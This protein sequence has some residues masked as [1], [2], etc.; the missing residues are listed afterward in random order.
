MATPLKETAETRK[1]TFDGSIDEI[2]VK[3]HKAFALYHGSDGKIRIGEQ[4]PER[5]HGEFGSAAE[6]DA[7]G[8]GFYGRAPRLPGAR[9]C[10]LANPPPD[11]VAPQHAQVLDE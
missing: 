10:Q 2:R 11:Q 4:P 6:N 8:H 1:D 5:R 7:Q 3:G 9:F